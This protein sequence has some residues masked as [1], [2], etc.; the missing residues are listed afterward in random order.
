MKGHKKKTSGLKNGQS[1]LRWLAVLMAV[2][3][4]GITAFQ[5]FWLMQN[6][7]REKRALLIKTSSAFRETVFHLQAT[8]LKLD[9]VDLIR[10]RGKPGMRVFVNTEDS[11]GDLPE[12]EGKEE[13]VSTINVIR[14]KFLDSMRKQKKPGMVI[15]MNNV[16]GHLVGDTMRFSRRLPSPENN[17]YI[18]NLLYGVDSLQDSIRLG[19][20]STAYA[21]QLKKQKIDIPF[22]INRFDSTPPAISK[23]NLVTVGFARPVIFQLQLGNSFPY[24]LKQLIQ[25]VLL[26][27]LLL[28]V[29]I[30]SFVLL[31][32][33]LVKQQRLSELKNEFISNIT[34]E[35]KTPLATVGVAIEAL[36]NFNALEDPNRTR[37]YLEISSNE[38]HRLG[39]LVDKVLKLSMFENKEM[40]LKYEPVDMRVLVDEV[41]DSL[42]LQFEKLQA[43]VTISQNGNVIVS[44]DR[45]H[46]LS[47]IFNL[48]D[49]ALKYSREKPVIHIELGGNEAQVMLLIKDNG[50]GIPAA[51]RGRIFEKFFRVPHGD[52][53]NAKGYG[54]GLSYVAQVVERHG[55]QIQ[56]DSEEGTGTT[57][58]I[59]FPAAANQ[60]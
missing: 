5:A 7:K 57:F 30:L 27:I 26:S 34:H 42:K 50:I 2:A 19:E 20:I 32:R 31:Y 44:G 55:G 52:T 11:I 25:P 10:R 14:D 53:H 43:T 28:A 46:L 18:V 59:L 39:L 13:I 45:L 23:E 22:T 8:K 3:I 21:R 29:T 9:D 48:V 1:R 51:Y 60:A 37:E 16:N 38:L 49:N 33:N 41:V 6:Y 24:I 15:R 36:K 4:L 58:K 12:P 54:L 40:D 47:V 56:V 17:N 35:L